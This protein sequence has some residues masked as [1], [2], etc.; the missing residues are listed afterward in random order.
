M[1]RLIAALLLIAALAAAGCAKKAAE[2]PAVEGN[3]APD[4]TLKDLSG[5]PVQLSTLKGKLVLVNF[6][7]TWCPPCREEI[8]SMV[9]LNQ[10]MQGK[11]FQML[12]VSIDEGGKT[13]VEDF[14]KRGGVTLPALLDTDG[15]VARRYGTTGV[16]E[17]F[18]VDPKGVIR[19]KVVG[20]LDWSHPEVMQALQ[21]LMADK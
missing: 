8:P 21:Q 3:P 6:W 12:A 1:K 10:A 17:T 19:K 13:A 11:N 20:G 4:F 2:A 16:P 9:K 5:K 18:V 14:F 7:A 15:Q